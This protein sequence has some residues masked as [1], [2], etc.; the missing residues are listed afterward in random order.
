MIQRVG[1]GR[2]DFGKIL[3]Y[4]SQDPCFFFPIFVVFPFYILVEAGYMG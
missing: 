4:V 3:L 1:K 2:V